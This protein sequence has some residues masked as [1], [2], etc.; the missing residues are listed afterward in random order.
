MPFVTLTF[1][2]HDH[3]HLFL[4]SPIIP[5][6]FG[7]RLWIKKTEIVF[8]DSNSIPEGSS[9]NNGQSEKIEVLTF[10]IF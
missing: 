4:I 2:K 6:K 8:D 9:E 3:V 1:S 7:E 5:P 10:R